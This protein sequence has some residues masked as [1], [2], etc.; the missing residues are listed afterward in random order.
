MVLPY[1]PY[2]KQPSGPYD[3]LPP[4]TA[5]ASTRWSEVGHAGSSS[6]G[7]L[8]PL[9]RSVTSLPSSMNQSNYSSFEMSRT[10]STNGSYSGIKSSCTCISGSG[11][12]ESLL[13]NNTY[14]T[15]RARSGKLMANLISKA[16]A[17]HVLTMDLHD[18]QYEGFFSI[19]V[20][21]LR[22]EPIFLKYLSDHFEGKTLQEIVIVSPDAGGAKRY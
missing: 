8:S 4:G 1:F 7:L 12:K 11:T 16:G 19:P 9:T 10:K 14:R 5:T 17:D 22:C 2:S 3:K 13:G 21:N 18:P 20:D 6:S 15:W